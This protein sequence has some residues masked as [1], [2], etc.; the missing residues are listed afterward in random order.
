MKR[1]NLRLWRWHK[2]KH[3]YRSYFDMLKM[4]AHTSNHGMFRSHRYKLRNHKGILNSEHVCV[5]KSNDLSTYSIRV[6]QLQTAFI[7]K[8]EPVA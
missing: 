4:L 1:N 2:K 3:I 8:T 6:Y 7:R 5:L